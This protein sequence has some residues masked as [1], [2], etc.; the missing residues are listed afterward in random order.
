MNPITKLT[1]QNVK[2]ILN[3]LLEEARRPPD[4]PYSAAFERRR[5]QSLRQQIKIVQ[6]FLEETRYEE[7]EDQVRYVEKLVKGRDGIMVEMKA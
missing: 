3:E 1:K 4:E 7:V 6:L 2:S 5:M